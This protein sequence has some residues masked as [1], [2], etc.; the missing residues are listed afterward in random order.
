MAGRPFRVAD[1]RTGLGLVHRQEHI[2]LV[3]IVD[4]R[5]RDSWGLVLAGLDRQVVH[6]PAEQ[7]EQPL[8]HGP[9]GPFAAA[10][11]PSCEPS[12]LFGFP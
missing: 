2:Q 3:A 5:Y 1:Q 8:D 11:L 6:L 7:L 12:T 4:E 9:L 10:L